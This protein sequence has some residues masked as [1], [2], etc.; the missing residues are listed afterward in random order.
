MIK[1][2]YMLPA[3]GLLAGLASPAL[4]GPAPI[5]GRWLATDPK[6]SIIVTIAPCGSALC[7]TVTEQ[8]SGTKGQRDI[9]NPDPKLRSRPITG[10]RLISG[11]VA[12]GTQWRGQ[13]Y[14]PTRG[15]T[16]KSFAALN[17]NGTLNLKGCWGFICQTRVWTRAR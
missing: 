16:F 2:R 1:M 4:A 17:P 7:G 15:K 10:I 8:V 14:D 9:N 13:I 5:T 11:M 6:G 12:D 3:L